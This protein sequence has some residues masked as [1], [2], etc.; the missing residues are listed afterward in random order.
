MTQQSLFAD[1][2]T[3]PECEA[4]FARK[5]HHHVRCSNAC[6]QRAWREAQ[7]P[8]TKRL[9]PGCGVRVDGRAI[10]CGGTCQ[11]RVK[12]WQNNG[13]MLTC[14]NPECPRNGILMVHSFERSVGAWC[15]NGCGQ[16]QWW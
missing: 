12:R 14:V 7:K 3:C 13:K 1:L 16:F 4:E 2:A 6:R 11:K 8:Q 15:C 9:C 10:Y 5:C